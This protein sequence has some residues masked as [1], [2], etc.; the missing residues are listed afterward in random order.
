MEWKE[1]GSSYCIQFS[2]S[3]S[4]LN[5]INELQDFNRN[6]KIKQKKTSNSFISSK[7]FILNRQRDNIYITNNSLTSSI[8]H[9]L[10]LLYNL[11][12]SIH[13]RASASSSYHLLEP[14]DLTTT[15][16]TLVTRLLLVSTL[17]GAGVVE[18]ERKRNTHALL[19]HV[20]PALTRYTKRA[21]TS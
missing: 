14:Y 13:L 21:F 1:L 19:L 16:W 17:P 9:I 11:K 8:P 6:Y 12:V 2:V 10:F 4:G 15:L 7:H 5:R 3:Y 18:E 20:P